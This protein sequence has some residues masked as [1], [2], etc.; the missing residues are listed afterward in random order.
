NMGSPGQNQVPLIRAEEGEPI[1]ELY[2][3]T[4]VE[5]D[6]GGN[7][8]LLDTNGDGTVDPD[9]RQVVGNGLPDFQF[10]LGNNFTYKNW[11]LN[12]YFRGV[13]GHDINNTYRAF[14]EVP[15]MIGSYNLPKTATDMRS[16]SG[17]L[18][19]NSSGVLSSYH[20]EDASFVALDNLSLGYNFDLPASSGFRNIRVYLSGNNLFYITGYDGV[21]PNP[22]YADNEPG[23]GTHN[24]PLVPGIDRRNTWFRTRSLSF[25]VNIGF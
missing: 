20:I 25:G 17:T 1:G 2:A 9:D 6:D 11:D 7:L 10:G 8:I 13:L 15:N 16:S 22:R 3:H 18:L 5:I 14:Y 19:N 4:Y 24:N 21:D 12:I 23:Q